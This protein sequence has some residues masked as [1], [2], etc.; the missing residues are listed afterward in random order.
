MLFW[1]NL[2]IKWKLSIIFLLLVLIPITVILLSV[3]NILETGFTQEHYR[4]GEHIIRLVNNLIATF[5]QDLQRSIPLLQQNGALLES[6]YLAMALKQKDELLKTVNALL[7]TLSFDI[8]EV[9]GLDGAI[10]VREYTSEKLSTEIETNADVLEKALQE[11]QVLDIAAYEDKILLRAFGPL[12]YQRVQIGTLMA[13]ILIDDSFAQKISEITGEEIAIFRGTSFVASSSQAFREACSRI[14]SEQHLSNE[15]TNNVIPNVEIEGINRT[16]LTAP[17]INHQG[18]SIGMIVVGLA[19]TELASIQNQSETTIMK[20]AGVLVLGT[21]LLVYGISLVT[22]RPLV[23]MREVASKI[24]QGDISQELPSTSK[25][26]EI[27]SLTR[28]F[29]AVVTYLQE[30]VQVATHISNG[31]LSYE[32]TPRSDQDVLG[33]AFQDM[34]AYL[35][36]I[37][38]VATAV[39]EGDLRQEVQP[40]AEGDVLGKAFQQLNSLRDTMR[41]IMNSAE[42]LGDASAVL[43]QVSDDIASGA[44]QSSNQIQVISSNGQQINQ[45]VNQVSA[46]IEELA[47]SIREISRNVHEVSQVI[48]SAVNITN[49]TNMT[50]TQLEARSQEIEAIIE[51]ITTIMQQTNLLALNA[52]IEAVRAG[53]VG[54][55]FAVVAHEIKELAR[56]TAASAEDI[57]HKVEAIQESTR[58]ATDAITKVSEITHHVHEL[59][60]SISIAVEQ[61]AAATDQISRNIIDT[62]HG[63]NEITHSIEEVATATQQASEQT[64]DVQ[65]AAQELADI[66]EQLRHLIKKFKI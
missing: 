60:S 31:D 52:T 19:R 20:V 34:S 1:N 32:I 14:L 50:I 41:E 8:L 45:N 13:G 61:Q 42:H 43:K 27:G 30:I 62:A 2:T 63:S 11:G 65:E 26:D 38:S 49:S 24:A 15:D 53:E 21:I 36:E 59:S 18:D 40:K 4:D 66:A 54:K 22:V 55:G 39:A 6:S 7:E 17:L 12:I 56:E 9:V 58:E 33:C 57:I 28:A 23:H 47:A 16:I 5:E 44:E 25:R 46:A 37:A 35:K 64:V 29:Q 51:V 10:L 48:E 3:S